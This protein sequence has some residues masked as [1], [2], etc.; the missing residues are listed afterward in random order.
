MSMEKDPELIEAAEILQVSWMATPSVLL[1]YVT[2][3]QNAKVRAA[4]YDGLNKLSLLP[5]GTLDAML[6]GLSRTEERDRAM[7]IIKKLGPTV[8]KDLQTQAIKG[9]SPDVRLQAVRLLGEIGGKDCIPTLQ[10]VIKNHAKPSPAL[11]AKYDEIRKVADES[12]EAIKKR[13]T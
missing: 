13:G 7:A 3:H 12:I 2:K 11:K 4:A 9:Q 6:V 5:T 10:T 8:E 1:Q